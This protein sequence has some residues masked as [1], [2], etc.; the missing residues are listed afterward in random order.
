[1]LSFS[2][3]SEWCSLIVL[4]TEVS[5]LFS[6]QFLLFIICDLHCLLFLLL[7]RYLIGLYFLYFG[8]IGGKL[9]EGLLLFNLI[10]NF[11]IFN[12]LLRLWFGNHN[13]FNT[14]DLLN[15]NYWLL[16]HFW[17]F[18]LNGGDLLN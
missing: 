13:F 12:R 6:L 2:D 11:G 5:L 4:A 1:M 18:L 10:L 16:V 3:K 8:F 17:N 14:N 7:S 9:A 15:D